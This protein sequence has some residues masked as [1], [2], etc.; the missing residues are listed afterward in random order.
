MFENGGEQVAAMRGRAEFVR[1]ADDR[2]DARR[3]IFRVEPGCEL[4]VDQQAVAPEHDGGVNAFTLPNGR[5]QI[6]N[7][8]HALRLPC[9]VVAKLGL[10]IVEVKRRQSLEQCHD[11]PVSFAL[12][13]PTHESSRYSPSRCRNSSRSPCAALAVVGVACGDLTGVPASLPTLTDSGTRVRDQRRAAGRADRA[14]RVQRHAAPGDASFI[15]DVAFDIDARGSRADLP[16]RVV[17]SGLSSTHSVGLQSDCGDFDALTSAPKSGY[18]AD[19]A[20]VTAL[21]RRSSRFRAADPNACSISLTGTT[22]YAKIVVTAVDPVAKQ[23]TVRYTVD[24]NCGFFSFASGIPK[25]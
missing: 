1:R 15:F 21:E 10:R 19:T 20:L 23:L 2:R 18:R 9:K 7:V 5:H 12:E 8:R 16:Q 13:P 24:P 17:A 6:S 11:A 3:D 4:A 25:D 22:L 14:A